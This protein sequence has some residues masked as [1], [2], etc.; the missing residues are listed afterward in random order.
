[1][2]KDNAFDCDKCLHN[3]VC[4]K[5]DICAFNGYCFDYVEKPRFK[6]GDCVECVVRDRTGK[7]VDICGYMFLTETAGMVIAASSAHRFD[8]L[9]VAVQDFIQETRRLSRTGFLVFPDADCYKTREGAYVA[10]WK[11]VDGE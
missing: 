3:E 6:P 10:Y 8:P 11:E 4:Q 9:H 5:Q 1:M 7:A 2:N